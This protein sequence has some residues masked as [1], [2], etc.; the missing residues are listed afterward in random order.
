MKPPSPAYGGTG[1]KGLL[2]IFIIMKQ[3]F[4][5]SKIFFQ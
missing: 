3:T 2:R 4:E 5:N 1:S